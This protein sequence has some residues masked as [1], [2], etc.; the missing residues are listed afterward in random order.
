M[1]VL[2]WVKCV[3]RRKIFLNLSGIHEQS[4]FGCSSQANEHGVYSD[5]DLSSFVLKNYEMERAGV[6]H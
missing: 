6:L 5:F 1:A 4:E 3:K 2:L